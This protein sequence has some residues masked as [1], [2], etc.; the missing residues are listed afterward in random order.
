MKEEENVLRIFNSTKKAFQNNN[1]SELKYLSN[2]TINT[3]ALTQDEDNIAAAVIVYSLSKIIER[4]DYRSLSGWNNFYKKI[5]I[6]IDDS[7]NDIKNKDYEGFRENIKKIRASIESLSGK[8]KKYIKEVFRNSEINKASR[9]HEHGI[10]LE[11]TA[12]LLGITMY[13]LADYVGKTGI[14]EVPE[15]QTMSVKSRIK[16][17]E[18]FFK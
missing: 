14:S 17:V 15:N 2:Q 13:E 8:L 3:A 11:K 10:S 5:N 4:Q 7:I 12:N 16:L 9:I 18:E 6:F 1:S